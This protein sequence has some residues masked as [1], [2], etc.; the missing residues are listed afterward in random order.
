MRD[1]K[2]L[3][4][5]R[6]RFGEITFHGEVMSRVGTIVELISLWNNPG[7][8][9]RDEETG[10]ELMVSSPDRLDTIELLPG[11]DS[12]QHT[13][14]LPVTPEQ[15]FQDV[16]S[17]PTVVRDTELKRWRYPKDPNFVVYDKETHVL[18]VDELL[19]QGRVVFPF[20]PIGGD[21]DIEAVRAGRA[22]YATKKPEPFTRP[23]MN[24]KMGEIWSL[25]GELYRL[26]RG[27]K[28][29]SVFVALP[30]V[31]A[32]KGYTPASITLARSRNVKEG[33][34]VA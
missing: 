32:Y 21:P 30:A 16:L 10:E 14:D 31:D 11:L 27:S 15:K 6:V 1:Y 25:D 29:A 26:V 28:T 18:V 3:V 13:A 17:S 5:Q 24:A 4:G 22:Y 12:N 19:G 7:V 20:K 33:Y 8:V 2:E 23:W 34:K 9:F